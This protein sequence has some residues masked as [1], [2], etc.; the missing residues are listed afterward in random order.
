MP[1]F[2][3]GLCLCTAATVVSSFIG[4]YVYEHHAKCMEEIEE[5]CLDKLGIDDTVVIDTIYFDK[6]SMPYK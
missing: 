3:V 5:D 6:Q 4:F 1:C 2:C